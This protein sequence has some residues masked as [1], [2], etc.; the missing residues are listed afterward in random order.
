[1]KPSTVAGTPF[2]AG[3]VPWSN[4]AARWKTG[5]DLRSVGSGT[6]SGTGLYEVAGFAPLA[7]AGICD[8][9]KGMVGPLLAGR[10]R[11]VLA[12]VAGGLAVA[13]HNWSPFL[14]GAGGRGISPAIGALAVTA[15]PGA[16]LL[17]GGLAAGRIVRE[18]GLGGFVADMA[19]VPV[20]L[21]THGR[22]GA[23]AGACVAPPMLLK[24]ALGNHRLEHASWRGY[25]ERLLFDRDPSS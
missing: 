4:V 10:D 23:M 5:V 8:I 6:V 16:V 11:P 3:A 14:R 2:V 20:L 22:R 18:T 25:T 7:I 13:G 9:A 17:L 1:V 15:W 19:L 24:R 12:A 21:I